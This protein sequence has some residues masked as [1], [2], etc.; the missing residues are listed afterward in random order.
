MQGLEYLENMKKIY[1]KPEIEVVTISLSLLTGSPRMDFK[2]KADSEE[3]VD[4]EV[5]NFDQLL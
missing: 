2:E 3:N 4:D 1:L 5:D